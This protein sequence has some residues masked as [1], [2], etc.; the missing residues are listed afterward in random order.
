[1]ASIYDAKSPPILIREQATR[2]GG[3]SPAVR[4]GRTPRNTT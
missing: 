3:Y 1:M 2:R 4:E